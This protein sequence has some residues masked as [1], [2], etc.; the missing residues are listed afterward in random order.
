MP[1]SRTPL[2]L[3]LAVA[4]CQCSRQPRAFPAPD[5]RSCRT[6]SPQSLRP[7]R[8]L[9]S[10]ANGRRESCAT[11]A[12]SAIMSRTRASLPDATKP[13]T[14]S[15]PS[16]RSIPRCLST[17]AATCACGGGRLGH[18]TEQRLPSHWRELSSVIWSRQRSYCDSSQAVAQPSLEDLRLRTL[19]ERQPRVSPRGAA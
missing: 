17:S 1:H 16:H 15:F 14:I 8:M 10:L 9:Q 18:R 3:Q 2:Q 19:A 13:S 6:Q 11:A 4:F 5:R 7:S 12:S